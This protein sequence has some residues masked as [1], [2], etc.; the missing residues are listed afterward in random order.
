M[1]LVAKTCQTKLIGSGFRVQRLKIFEI[2]YR[3]NQDLEFPI[4]PI[5]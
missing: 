2:T 1:V 5:G 3:I 4:S